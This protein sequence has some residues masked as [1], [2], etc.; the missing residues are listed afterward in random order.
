MRS[1]I[2]ALR[3]A[4]PRLIATAFSRDGS[5]GAQ[6]TSVP[7]VPMRWEYTAQVHSSLV[8]VVLNRLNCGWQF[9]SDPVA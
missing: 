5:I 3:L 7:F 8:Q 1:D 4:L 9:S 6:E 2:G